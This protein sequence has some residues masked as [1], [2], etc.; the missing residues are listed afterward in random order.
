[1]FLKITNSFL[2]GPVRQYSHAHPEGDRV[3]RE[4]RPLCRPE[5]Q[6]R[7]GV[8]LK[9]TVRS[10]FLKKKTYL[11]L[12]LGINL[13]PNLASSLV[14]LIEILVLNKFKI[15]FDANLG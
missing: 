15:V 2:S 10:G 6:N 3:H 13:C 9:V 14:D 7:T 1:M 8:R 12:F 4:V 5:M 11:K